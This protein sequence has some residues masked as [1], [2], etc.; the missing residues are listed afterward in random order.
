MAACLGKLTAWTF[1]VPTHTHARCHYQPPLETISPFS[2]TITHPLASWLVSAY[3]HIALSPLQISG[4]L[5]APVTRQP[6]PGVPAHLPAPTLQ[7][8]TRS[9]SRASLTPSSAPAQ[10]LSSLSDPRTQ[11]LLCTGLHSTRARSAPSRPRWGAPQSCGCK[12]MADPKSV[13]LFDRSNRHAATHS[14]PDSPAVSTNCSMRARRRWRRLWRRSG[15]SSVLRWGE[16]GRG[17]AQR[18]WRRGH[19]GRGGAG[20]V[21]DAEYPS[22]V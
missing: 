11:P 5:L 22:E 4:P 10:R 9:L 14:E 8:P 12:F 16:M 13:R 18:R 21:G 7:Q 17:R 1:G 20:L 6:A 19:W 3:S 15:R 2:L